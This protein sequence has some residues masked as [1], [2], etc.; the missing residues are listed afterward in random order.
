ML[1]LNLFKDQLKDLIGQEPFQIRASFE[2]NIIFINAIL[3]ILSNI[4]QHEILTCDDK[5]PPWFNKK[6][7]G[8]FLDKSSTFKAY[9]SNSSNIVLKNCLRNFQICLNSSIEC[10][11]EK[12][13]HRVANKLNDTHKNAKAY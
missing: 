7:N 1:I 5:D 10:T 8:K 11:K 6:I 4:I 13:Y 9:R 12:F 3:N 2:M